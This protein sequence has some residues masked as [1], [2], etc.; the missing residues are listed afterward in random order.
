MVEHRT[1][2]IDSISPK[3]FL[4]FLEIYEVFIFSPQIMEPLETNVKPKLTEYLK[5]LK[6]S[7]TS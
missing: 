6:D 1:F 4:K 7:L 2:K 5:R 3:Y